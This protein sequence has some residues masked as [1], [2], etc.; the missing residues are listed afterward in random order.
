M[1][2]VLGQSSVS[3]ADF[4]GE[5]EVGATYA[6]IDHES[7]KF[8]EY[9]GIRGNETYFLGN[10]D[11]SYTDKNY[12]L[13]VIGKDLGIDTRNIYLQGG[14]YGSYK[15]FLEYDQTP[16]FIS[17]TSRTIFNGAGGANLTLPAGY[18]RIV[19]PAGFSNVGQ[20][21][22]TALLNELTAKGG[23]LHNVDLKLER[24]SGTAG[25]SITSFKGL[26]DF[27]LSAKHEEKDGIKSIGAVVQGN[28]EG[29]GGVRNSVILPE[30]VDYVTDELR[31][32]VAYTREKAQLELEYYLSVFN[33]ETESLKWQNPFRYGAA[34]PVISLPP[35]N[36]YQRLTLS[37][38]YN[39]PYNTRVS[40]AAEYGKMSQDQDLLPY[41]ADPNAAA[42]YGTLPRSSA[43][44]EIETKLLNVN[45]SSRPVSALSVNA[46]YRHYDTVNM[47]PVNLFTYAMADGVTPPATYVAT[48]ANRSRRNAPFDYDQNKATVDISYRLIQNT[49]LNLGYDRDEIAREHREQEKTRED[50]YR[51]GLK[52]NLSFASAGV[53]YLKGMRRGDVAYNG[54]AIMD[55]HPLTTDPWVNHPDLRK[56]DVAD[57]DREKYDY[58]VTIM[59]MKNASVGVNVANGWDQYPDTKM[60]LL[61]SDFS[62]YT[63]N[64]SY[65]PV[66]EV[67]LH[68]YYTYDTS[69]S[70]Q[71]GRVMTSTPAT[72]TDTTRDWTSANKDYTDTVGVGADVSFF[73]GKLVVTPDYT[74]AR[75]ITTIDI[76]GGSYFVGA[77]A[78]A[79]LPDLRTERHTL[80]LSG[81]YRLTD[82]LTLGANY[83]YESYVSTD[84]AVDGMTL[85][86]TSTLPIDKPLVPLSGSVP[87]YTANVGTITIAYRF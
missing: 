52:S 72:W 25:F 59:P 81:K 30:P 66:Q 64:A 43:K 57:R 69:S 28:A 70:K 65:A 8:S 26:V 62:S 16:K 49:A 14:S 73:R 34:E 42:T 23:S 75:S 47:T 13:N 82:R 31:A 86:N 68:T 6:G 71:Y 5:V 63:V 41:H 2:S 15:Y 1:I 78:I 36:R 33:N 11:L 56:F 67:N 55:S 9:R 12:Y 38:G 40:M 17:N 84:W 7:S 39:L 61:N 51:A 80:N 22:V 46:K 85:D 27:T 53:N 87:D 24:K 60:G 77:N 54:N 4:K 79:P 76:N 21:T 58:F 35:D 18:N 19:L 29:Q 74:Y 20:T 83:L 44:A 10:L 45:V 37:G 50:I 32:S 3:F 48:T